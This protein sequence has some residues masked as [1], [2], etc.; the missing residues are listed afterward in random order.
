MTAKWTICDTWYMPSIATDFICCPL[1]AWA[2]S[3]TTRRKTWQW[4]LVT[5]TLSLPVALHLSCNLHKIV[6]F[7]LRLQLG[8][9]TGRL[10][11]GLGLV[12]YESIVVKMNKT[13]TKTI[14][15]MK[16]APTVLNENKCAICT[17]NTSPI[18]KVLGIFDRVLENYR[19][20]NEYKPFV[21]VYYEMGY[22]ISVSLRLS[23]FWL[24]VASNRKYKLWQVQQSSVPSQ[25]MAYNSDVLSYS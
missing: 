17:K 8:I 12:Y 13:V 5:L 23:V 3:A 7:K 10:Q 16:S 25:P 19:K 11:S 2:S 18:Y 6:S 9:Y 15:L 14:K 1:Q 22:M 24:H 20:I 4:G 21:I